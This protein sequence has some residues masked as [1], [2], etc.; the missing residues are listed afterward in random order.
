MN[1]SNV[2][3]RFEDRVSEHERPF[4]FGLTLASARIRANNETEATEMDAEAPELQVCA[5][6]PVARDLC[7]HMSF[8]RHP[9]PHCVRLTA[10]LQGARAKGLVVLL[11]RP[12]HGGEFRRLRRGRLG[13]D[14]RV[15]GR[16]PRRQARFRRSETHPRAYSTGPRRALAGMLSVNRWCTYRHVCLPA[17]D[18]CVHFVARSRTGGMCRG[19]AM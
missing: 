11:G 3:V 18:I 9:H 6:G 8:P 13:S 5:T 1:V 2:H 17:C 12:R 19:T 7:C 16:L 14:V 4:A 15:H 10:H